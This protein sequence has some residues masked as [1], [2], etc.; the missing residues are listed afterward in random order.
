MQRTGGTDELAASM[1]PAFRA[2][3]AAVSLNTQA[4]CER[5]GLHLVDV[6]AINLLA[7]LGPVPVGRLS[8]HLGTPTTT[9]T[10]VVDRLERAG[11]LRR[12]SDPEDRRKVI[13]ELVPERVREVEE[14]FA[15]SR[16]HLA[17]LRE[18]YTDQ[19]LALLLDMFTRT[20][21][22]FRSATAEIRAGGTTP[23][24]LNGPT[25]R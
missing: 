11:Y 10:R 1:E 7:A 9:T 24:P 19:D 4:G 22:A 20:T 6:Q 17:A 2:F 12:R 5:L 23:Q 21:Q 18:H 13:A 8:E 15:P 16:Q 14:V 25:S 3:V